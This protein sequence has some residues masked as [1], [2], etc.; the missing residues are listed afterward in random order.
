MNRAN[1]STTTSPSSRPAP[2]TFLGALQYQ[3]RTFRV[4]AGP[5]PGTL[6]L[7]L[8]STEMGAIYT[9]G[10]YQALVQPSEAALGL[11][12]LEG[13]WTIVGVYFISDPL[14]S[15][16]YTH[17]GPR[18][19]KGLPALLGRDPAGS[20]YVAQPFVAPIGAGR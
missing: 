5:M 4:L 18:A 7:A 13:G 12:A 15:N 17:D 1:S 16:L 9:E 2:G 6:S 20:W 10:T 8:P 3:E 11:E 14:V 19:Y